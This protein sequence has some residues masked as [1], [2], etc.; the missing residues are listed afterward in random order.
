M[1]GLFDRVKRDEGFR[2]YPYRCS[3][4]ALTIGYGRNIDEYHGGGGINVIEEVTTGD[5]FEIACIRTDAGGTSYQDDNG[6]R[7]NIWEIG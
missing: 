5:Y 1:T 7:F 6:T 4:G 3:A 2:R